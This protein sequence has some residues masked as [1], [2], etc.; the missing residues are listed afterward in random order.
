MPFTFSINGNT[1]QPSGDFIGLTEGGYEVNT[2]DI[3]G[4]AASE[5]IFI[6]S[7]IPVLVD[8]GD[9]L[10]IEFGS[11]TTFQVIVNVPYDSLTSI[12]W[13]PLESLECPECQTQNVAPLITSTYSVSVT[14]VNGCTDEDA[15]TVYVD[16][17]KNIYVPNA[18][19][20]NGDGQNNFVAVL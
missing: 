4:C 2:V 10:F 19:S 14:D 20:P 5:I 18:F 1:P 3:N 9:D 7:P 17:S 13:Q 15:L 6:N 16:R 12:L 11:D 8:L